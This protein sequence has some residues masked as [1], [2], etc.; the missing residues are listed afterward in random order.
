MFS[1]PN[2]AT[3]RLCST[4]ESV[5]YALIFLVLW[6]RRRH[7]TYL[8]DW[9]VSSAFYAAS[10]I[11]FELPLPLPPM[12][13]NGIAYG[14]V[15]ASD[16]LILSGMRRF[17][18]NPP[19]AA[20]M[21]APFLL[22]VLTAMV[23][24]IVWSEPETAT[25][26]MRAGSAAAL[27][28]CMICCIVG[29]LA[30]RERGGRL[31][32]R[33]VAAALAA[34]VPGYVLSMAAQLLHVGDYGGLG[35]LPMVQ[36][37]IL[38]PILNL[39]LLATPWDRAMR[40]LQDSVLRDALTGAW[41]RAALKRRDAELAIPSTSLFLIDIDHFKRIND[42]YGHAAGD[43]VLIALS[44]RLE[45]MAAEHDGLFVRLGGDEFVMVIPTADDGTAQRLAEQV[46]TVPGPA[47]SGLPAYSLSIGLSRVQS[48]ETGLS[49]ALARADRSLYLAKERGRDQVAA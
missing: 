12:I 43:S 23:P 24:W 20:W 28:L 36:D 35:L 40:T 10:L 6:A 38:L 37:Q 45:A 34:Y 31:P 18:G 7:E 30:G 11:V 13:A 29:I 42:T 41:N 1:P 46:R 9:G 4:L 17:D 48:G 5:A 2:L 21:L 3:L 39:A 16:L 27:A 32:R 19:F 33:I 47:A 44:G 49:S 15:A 8:I 22:P 25:Y 26:I 14:L